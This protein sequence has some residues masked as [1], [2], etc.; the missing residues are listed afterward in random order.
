MS[1][2][3]F[4]ELG[5][6]V[7]FQLPGT[8]P[9]EDEAEEA[10]QERQGQP[11]SIEQTVR[12]MRRGTRALQ[13][14]NRR[15]TDSYVS[16]P[17]LDNEEPSEQE[18]ERRRRR[19]ASEI[20]IG[21][22]AG[23]EPVRRSPEPSA[24]R[25]GLAGLSQG[26]SLGFADEIGAAVRAPFSDRTYEEIRNQD[27]RELD[28]LRQE[29]PYA[30]HGG[31]ILGGLGLGAGAIGGAAPA[32]VR[33]MAAQGMRQ[34]AGFGAGAGAGYSEAEDTEGLLDDVAASAVLGGGI[35][36]AVAPL[37]GAA[38]RGLGR[39]GDAWLERGNLLR[40]K[41]AGGG[42]RMSQL[43]DFERLPPPRS[44]VGPTGGDTNAE[45]VALELSRMRTPASATSPQGERVFGRFNMAS[46]EAIRDNLREVMDQSREVFRRVF[47]DVDERVAVAPV[48]EE[49]RN[50]RGRFTVDDQQAPN[51]QR[52]LSHLRRQEKE[53]ERFVE[54]GMPIQNAQDSIDLLRSRINWAQDP[55]SMAR[56]QDLNRDISRAMRRGMDDA[57]ERSSLGE[58]GR[59]DYQA[60]RRAY[61]LLRTLERQ[62]MDNALRGAG[63]RQV[64]FSD[65][66]AGV[67]G[68]I[69]AA[70]GNR[71]LRANEARVFG[72]VQRLLSRP[73]RA[74]G[75]T[76]GA[77]GV[78]A[79]A[80]AS[81]TGEG[82]AGV[83]DAVQQPMGQR[84]SEA[85]GEPPLYDIY[86]EESFTET[87]EEDG[88]P[89]LYDPYD[90]ALIE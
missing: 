15:L 89:P 70:I 86:E 13:Q 12:R 74:A 78:R 3:S 37:A 9:T 23:P 76:A 32:T 57:V 81:T 71:A 7:F 36:G 83:A 63:N 43:R 42:A 61:Q 65:Y 16:S 31:E 25:A 45:R 46:D 34:G 50:L 56:A 84:V 88:L 22:T 54:N 59:R 33:S 73:M 6:D 85:D 69:P 48:L 62:Q 75:Q 18:R 66:Q 26:M 27:R 4:R 67:G 20:N 19:V 51:A 14:Q 90:D 68:G 29:S 35:G 58:Q 39:L 49:I 52:F 40:L 28:R 80:T 53:F 72:E 82:V 77:A 79:G 38:S 10:P 21:G 11:L 8:R 87:E 47:D 55:Q 17:T 30:Y 5:G 41:R 1:E 24:L 44:G 60:A 2:E 64:S